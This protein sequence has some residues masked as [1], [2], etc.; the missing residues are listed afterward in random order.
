MA[1]TMAVILGFVAKYRILRRVKKTVDAIRA[2]K[3]RRDHGK[4]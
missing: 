4:R 3:G 1:T 2:G